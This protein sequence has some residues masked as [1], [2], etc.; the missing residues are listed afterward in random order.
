ME[1]EEER[2]VGSNGN[3]SLIK[4]KLTKNLLAL[5]KSFLLHEAEW[6]GLTNRGCDAIVASDA[7]SGP[8]TISICRNLT[9]LIFATL[10]QS[11]F[12]DLLLMV[13]LHRY[14]VTSALVRQRLLAECHSSSVLTLPAFQFHRRSSYEFADACEEL[15]A[16]C[17]TVNL[18]L[19]EVAI[20]LGEGEVEEG[21]EAKGR[22]K[23]DG[24]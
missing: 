8:M 5:G 22:K 7:D 3:T 6:A 20:V 1:E 11:H 21:E 9:A 2:V 15:D 16:A 19:H 10:L 13:S 17:V 18:T 4:S 12:A 24:R 14:A 23:D